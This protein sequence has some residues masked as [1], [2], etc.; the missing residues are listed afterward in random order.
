MTVCSTSNLDEKCEE[1]TKENTSEAVLNSMNSIESIESSD[2]EQ[3][4][5]TGHQRKSGKYFGSSVRPV[6]FMVETG[7]SQSRLCIGVSFPHKILLDNPSNCSSVSIHHVAHEFPP[8]NHVLYCGS[9]ADFQSF[10][11]VLH[12]EL[13]AELLRLSKTF[14]FVFY[15]DLFFFCVM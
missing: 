13:I 9:A 11:G 15:F 10:F 7:F 8:M 2:S 6:V 14:I 4:Q 3:E 12:A 1:L 5:T